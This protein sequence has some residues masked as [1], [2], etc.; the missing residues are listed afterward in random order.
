MASLH[1]R[2]AISPSKCNGTP[3]SP[4][5]PSLSP[6]SLHSDYPADT[7]RDLHVV[8]QQQR[9]H[10]SYSIDSEMVQ[11]RPGRELRVH[12][13]FPKSLEDGVRAEEHN[14]SNSASTGQISHHQ[15]RGD[16]VG[17]ETDLGNFLNSDK[18]SS[19]TGDDALDSCETFTQ[20]GGTCAQSI[21][22]SKTDK[23]DTILKC[24]AT[25]KSDILVS[26]IS[27]TAANPDTTTM[28]VFLV[29]GVGGSSIGTWHA[30]ID[31]LVDKLGLTIIGVDLI[32]HGSSDAPLECSEYTFSEMSTD[33]L[34]VFDKYCGMENVI[35]GHSYGLVA[36]YVTF[37]I[38]D[39]MYMSV[40]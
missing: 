23:P 12:R 7:Y 20:L 26:S 14:I 28:I 11:I 5:Q 21:S 22:R 35:I 39:S 19:F 34:T 13:Y 8:S 3:A 38:N 4:C 25:S 27:E 18:N 2:N 40:N 1:S 37:S 33:I 10:G 6:T 30:Q 32:G 16:T 36:A 24:N 15:T 9:R 29:H 17:C 31:L